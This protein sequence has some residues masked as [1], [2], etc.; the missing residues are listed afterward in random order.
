[1][2]NV[3]KKKQFF[4]VFFNPFVCANFYFNLQDGKGRDKIH[5]I[6]PESNKEI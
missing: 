3:F 5:L 1:M 4:F 6:F 2:S